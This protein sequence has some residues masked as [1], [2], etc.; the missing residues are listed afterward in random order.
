MTQSQIII[1]AVLAALLVAEAAAP[2]FVEQ[3][4]NWRELLRHDLRNLLLGAVNAL[5]LAPIFATALLVIEYQV[6]MRG[7]G[8]LNWLHLHLSTPKWLTMGL[9]LV[10]FDLWMYWWHRLNH[11]VPFLWRFHRM[12]HSDLAMDASTGVR[13]HPG[14]ILLSGLARLIVLPVLGMPLTLLLVY[15]AILLPVVLFHHAN[16]R[17]PRWLDFR[18]FQG[19][20]LV[21]PAMHRVHHSRRR[22]ETNSNYASVLP[23]WDRLFGTLR[24]REDVKNIDYGLEDFGD[25]PSQTLIGMLKT[26]LVSK[27][28][29]DDSP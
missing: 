28:T 16:I 4:R 12:H 24:V 19:G 13:F 8:L 22:A 25:E 7:F 21:T 29:R 18:L 14:E 10:L 2:F 27:R 15:E 17:V 6:T 5:C 9:G 11:A 3:R 23:V 20:L 26:P 1:A